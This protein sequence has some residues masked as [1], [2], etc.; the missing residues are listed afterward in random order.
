MRACVRAEASKHLPV[1]VSQSA[2]FLYIVVLHQ[3]WLVELSR[4]QYYLDCDYMFDLF[5]CIEVYSCKVSLLL[6]QLISEFCQQI[7]KLY[8]SCHEVKNFSVNLLHSMLRYLLQ[9]L[10]SS[11]NMTVFAHQHDSYSWEWQQQCC[12]QCKQ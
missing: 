12:Q 4:F 5:D 3:L 8:S 6:S 11:S 7:I 9:S 10:K 1:H 2:S